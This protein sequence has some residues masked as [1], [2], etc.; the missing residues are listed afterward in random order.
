MRQT[1]SLEIKVGIVSII[2]LALL[3]FGITLGKGLNISQSGQEI[4]LEFPNSGGILESAPVVVNGVKRGAVTSVEN[5]SSGVRITANLDKITDIHADATA[6][7]T[8]L[9]I[10]GGKKIEIFPGSSHNMLNNNDVI[11]GTTA[12]DISELVTLV[13]DISGDAVVMFRRLDTALAEV[14][15]LLNDEKFIG[16]LK[17]TAQNANDL[18]SNAN[19]FFNDNKHQLQQSLDD[20]SELTSELNDAIKTNRPDIDRIVQKLDTTIS[21]TNKIIDK[22]DITLEDAQ[23]IAQNLNEITNKIN[24]GDG[25]ASEL[26]N[27]KEFSNNIESTIKLLKEYLEKIEEHG[28]NVNAR[29]GSRP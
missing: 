20:I 5:T 25:L 4:I 28:I 3:I 26:I 19:T 15:I 23:I 12:A 2:A 21:K 29:L 18:T 17:Q 10:T 16:N 22:T 1:K 14:N 24:S 6:K 8:M 11:H 9:E 13:G 7:I 27:N